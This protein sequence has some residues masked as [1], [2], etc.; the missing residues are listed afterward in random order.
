VHEED[1]QNRR[2]ELERVE[3]LGNSAGNSIDMIIQL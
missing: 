1:I 2:E 3:I